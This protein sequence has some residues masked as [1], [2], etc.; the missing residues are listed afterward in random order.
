MKSQAR[1]WSL[2]LLILFAAGVWL[3]PALSA[4]RD[5]VQPGDKKEETREERYATLI[6]KKAPE[7]I[8]DFALTGQ[9]V[10]LSELRGKVVLVDFWAVWCGPCIATFPHLTEWHT[11]FRD[12]GL[13]VVGVTTYQ[14]YYQ[15]D[16]ELGRVKYIGE[17]EEDK[18][19]G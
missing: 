2:C 13:E 8:G 10:K 18:E 3:M 11:E 17:K 4:Q 12:Q 19:T 5:S 6:G 16:K 7:M 9:P 1:R 15:F 14:K